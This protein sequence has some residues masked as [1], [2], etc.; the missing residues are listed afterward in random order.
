MT[1]FSSLEITMNFV[2]KDHSSNGERGI[3]INPVILEQ[4]G[5]VI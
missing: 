5:G 1:E 2:K 3:F 4:I